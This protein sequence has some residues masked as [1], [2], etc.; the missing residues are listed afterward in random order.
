MAPQDELKAAQN[1]ETTTAEA[2]YKGVTEF[3]KWTSTLSLAAI[4]WVGQTLK[5]TGEGL[6]RYC[7][8]A[9]LLFLISS[10]IVAVVTFWWVLKGWANNW[11]ANQELYA[12]LGNKFVGESVII[13][14]DEQVEGLLRA[15]K[16]AGPFQDPSTFDHRVFAHSVLLLAGLV[17]YVMAQILAL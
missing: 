15:V 13:A 1:E 5:D 14:N 7:F 8:I 3:V 11:K 2:F 16:K 9:S 6:A 17:L 10:L 12:T 4:L